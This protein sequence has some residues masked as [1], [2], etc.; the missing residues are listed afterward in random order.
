MTDLEMLLAKDMMREKIY[1]YSRC[2]DRCDNALCDD[3]F[4]LDCTMD[5]GKEYRG[6]ARGFVEWVEDEH[7]RN[8]EYT[9]HQYTDITI[10]FKSDTEAV[11]ETYAILSLFG[12]P[13]AMG[14][15]PNRRKILN[16][17]ARYLDRWRKC[18][19]GQWRICERHLCNEQNNLYDVSYYAGSYN[20]RR[21]KEDLVYKLFH[22]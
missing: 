11:S 18:E 4:T 7:R 6:S 10:K 15:K 16:I 20:S 22:S 19:D 14:A 12:W 17:Y 5:Y 21:D 13:G 3:I 9:S 2:M 1:L 8:Y